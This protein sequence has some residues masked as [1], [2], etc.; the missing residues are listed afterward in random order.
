MPLRSLQSLSGDD[1]AVLT[2]VLDEC[3]MIKL[4]EELE[5]LRHI[6]RISSFAHIEVPLAHRWR[7]ARRHPLPPAARRRPPP[8]AARRRACAGNEAHAAG[9]A[10]VRAGGAVPVHHV[11]RGGDG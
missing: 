4:P 10:R 9:H 6:N 1:G 2:D 8:P 11:R 3:R 5:L 7:D